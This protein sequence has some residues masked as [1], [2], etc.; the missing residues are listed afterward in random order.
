MWK[1]TQYLQKTSFTSNFQSCFSSLVSHV[2]NLSLPHLCLLPLLSFLSRLSVLSL[3]YLCPNMS[4]NVAVKK[5]RYAVAKNTTKPE[6]AFCALH[7]VSSNKIIYSF[8]PFRFDVSLKCLIL[9]NTCSLALHVI[10]VCSNPTTPGGIPS[11][12][13]NPA[14]GHCYHLLDYNRLP[15]QDL[16]ECFERKGC[17]TVPILQFYEYWSK[18]GVR[19]RGGS[20]RC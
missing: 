7:V 3:L 17:H 4:Q 9:L 12:L 16:R 10:H 2:P 15:L 18:G 6:I 20:N 13:G 11:N 5:F 1:S 19:G 8:A 14:P